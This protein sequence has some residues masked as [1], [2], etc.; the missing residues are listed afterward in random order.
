MVELDFHWKR[1]SWV[2][3]KNCKYCSVF[4]TYKYVQTLETFYF[5]LLVETT[6]TKHV[7]KSKVTRTIYWI[8]HASIYDHNSKTNQAWS[9]DF[10]HFLLKASEKY[11]KKTCRKTCKNRKWEIFSEGTRVMYIPWLRFKN[12][13]SFFF[14]LSFGSLTLNI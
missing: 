8:D 13:I 2:N 11:K 3:D 6:I 10:I 12:S 5:L 7:I 4:N 9:T 14:F 1:F